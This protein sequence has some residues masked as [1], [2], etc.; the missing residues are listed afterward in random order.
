MNNIAFK[1]SLIKGAAGTGVDKTIPEDGVIYYDGETAPEGYTQTT[2]PTGG[3]GGGSYEET[4]LWY[5]ADGAYTGNITLDRAYTNYN[6]LIIKCASLLEN[7]I[8]WFVYL[9]VSEI[10]NNIT[11]INIGTRIAGADIDAGITI[12]DSTTITVNSAN[13]AN[14]VYKIIGVKY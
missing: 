3:G 7:N 9:P 12:V 14:K 5:D 6:A 2:D 4:T 10:N 1:T 11:S 13:N 8:V